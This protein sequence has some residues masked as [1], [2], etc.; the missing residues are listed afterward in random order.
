M[1][2]SAAAR[3]FVTYPTLAAVLI[4]LVPALSAAQEPVKSFDQ[5]NTRLKVGDTVWVTDAEGREIKGRIRG[6]SATSLLLDAGG[7]P[8]DLQAARVRTI[9][10]QQSDSLTNGTLIGLA[11]GGAAGALVM[12]PEYECDDGPVIAV[13]WLGAAA[14]AGIGAL[15]DAARGGKKV[16]TYRAPGALSSARL[17]IAPV[18]T[19]RTKGVAVAFSF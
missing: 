17:S 15:I 12:V 4:V 16:L 3:Q 9:R 11:V 8:Q 10:M 6:L 19:P 1:A 18:I 2:A 7:A 14:G 5:L 13:V